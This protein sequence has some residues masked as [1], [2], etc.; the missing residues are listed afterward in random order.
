M[1][2]QGID[3]VK[4]GSCG[5]KILRR[6]PD[7]RLEFVFGRSLAGKSAVRMVIAGEV[8]MVCLRRHCDHINVVKSEEVRK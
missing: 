5:K 7:G 2:D 6:L 8:E 1:G 4:C 3:F